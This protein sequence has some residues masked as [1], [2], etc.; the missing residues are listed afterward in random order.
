MKFSNYNYK[1]VLVGIVATS[2]PF[3]ALGFKFGAEGAVLIFVVTVGILLFGKFLIYLF[4]RRSKL[5]KGTAIAM[6]WYMVFLLFLPKHLR[7]EMGR[8]KESEDK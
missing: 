3:I 1:Y 6:N 7:E 8:L 4:M 5:A 2:I